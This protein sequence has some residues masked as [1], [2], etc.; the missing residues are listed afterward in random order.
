MEKVYCPRRGRSPYSWSIKQ[1]NP[2]ALALGF[3][4][5]NF[6]GID[7]KMWVVWG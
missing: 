2:D 5:F 1:F 4:C 3:Y 6:V 7:R